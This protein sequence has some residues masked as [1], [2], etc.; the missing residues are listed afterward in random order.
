M[1]LVLLQAQV[2]L[3]RTGCS[4]TAQILLQKS[5]PRPQ[6]LCDLYMH[7]IIARKIRMAP[8]CVQSLGGSVID[9]KR[10]YI[11]GTLHW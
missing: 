4:Q 5:L 7:C 2:Q 11:W 3:S 10:E 1:L 6:L 9:G 8:W